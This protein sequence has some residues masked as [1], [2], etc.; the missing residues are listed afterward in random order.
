[1]LLLFLTH[2]SLVLFLI[3][4]LKKTLQGYL[5]FQKNGNLT[6]FREKNIP[7]EGY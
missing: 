7:K 6:F 2:L 3:Y 1:M 4:D 5:F